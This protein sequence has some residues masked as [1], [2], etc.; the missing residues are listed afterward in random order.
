MEKR[1]YWGYR[2]NKE[3]RKFFY[4]ELIVGRLRQGWGYHEGQNLKNLTF[5]EGAKRNLAMLKVK[6]GDILLVPSITKFNE[7]AIIEATDD[8]DEKYKFEIS[9]DYN[10]YGHIFPA[11]LIKAFDRNNRNIPSDLKRTLKNLQRFWNID[12]CREIIEDLLKREEDLKEPE[13]KNEILKIITDEAFQRILEEGNF[14]NKIKEAY[15]NKFYNAEW[16]EV[17]TYGLNKL[18]P[19]YVT[20]KIG[21]VKEN[22]HGADILVRIPSIIPDYNY[23]IAIQVK[24]YKDIIDEKTS[25]LIIE[26]IE[27]ADN[28]PEWDVK[29]I[30][31]I[32]IITNSEEEKNLYLKNKG[33]E[34]N[35]KIIF[36]KEFEELLISMAKSVI[37]IN[38]Y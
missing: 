19:S 21:G 34:K 31:K 30:D 33:Q 18:F 36:K 27:K 3:V 15:R 4:E 25:D 12:Y 28:Y 17:I 35:I 20:N 14:N 5:D 32:I 29:L 1:R 8:W 7:I 10:D 24:D 2:I 11:K 23:G 37:G 16:E 22:E 26:Q 38:V 9:K 13:E 6:K